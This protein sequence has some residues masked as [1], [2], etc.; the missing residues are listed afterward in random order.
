MRG[1]DLKSNSNPPNRASM[2]K[3]KHHHPPVLKTAA[4]IYP[5][6][7]TSISSGYPAEHPHPP[8]PAVRSRRCPLHDG[9]SSLK[10][11]GSFKTSGYIANSICSGSGY[12]T[13]STSSSSASTF[14]YGPATRH[15]ARPADDGGS[16]VIADDVEDIHGTQ[17]FT[18][19][20]YH[21]VTNG[22][23]S[24]V[25]LENFLAME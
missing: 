24:N 5:T 18:T 8:R 7:T 25:E 2:V 3:H 11:S 15:G 12:L 1:I 9:Q 23:L 13:S 16:A 10:L 20:A 21:R 4:I 19:A 22:P 14:F 17:L 6:N